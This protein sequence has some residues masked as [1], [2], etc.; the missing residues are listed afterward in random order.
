MEVSCLAQPIQNRLSTS[1]QI[2]EA[3]K[4]LHSGAIVYSKKCCVLPLSE[5]LRA[6]Q[7]SSKISI[8]LID[9]VHLDSFF[10]HGGEIFFLFEFCA[11][12]RDK[13]WLLSQ[14]YIEMAAEETVR[15]A[16]KSSFRFVNRSSRPVG[17]AIGEFRR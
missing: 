2:N 1:K 14:T 11:V 15:I 9:N 7:K 3:R 13:R 8:D 10:L 5:I 17:D 16:I 4:I 6:V 12:L